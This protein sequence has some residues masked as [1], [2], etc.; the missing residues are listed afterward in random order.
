M[1]DQGTAK[2]VRETE[3]LIGKTETM[4]LNSLVH[5]RPYCLSFTSRLD[6][7]ACLDYTWSRMTE[8]EKRV[9]NYCHIHMSLNL[10]PPGFPLHTECLQMEFKQSSLMFCA[11]R[12]GETTGMNLR[13]KPVVLCTLKSS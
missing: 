2:E 8:E 9:L 3:A 11:I 12:W 1:L 5:D 10:H 6:L 4:L 13:A 7:P